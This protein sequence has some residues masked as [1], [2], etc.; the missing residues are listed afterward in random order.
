MAACALKN[1]FIA[2]ALLCATPALAQVKDLNLN[3]GKCE[4]TLISKVGH[5]IEGNSEFSRTSG[6][7]VTFANGAFLVS[8]SE[9]AVVRGSKV[10]DPVLL[11]TVSTQQGCP[12]GR[13][14]SKTIVMVNLKTSRFWK[15]D[16]SSHSCDGA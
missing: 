9:S 13:P 16:T 1:S 8:Y 12:A 6:S 3:E 7:A 2:L 14:P 15:A 5:R 10:G 4:S 11:C